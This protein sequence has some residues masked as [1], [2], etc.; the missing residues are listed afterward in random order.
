MKFLRT[1]AIHLFIFAL[2]GLPML[3]VAAQ[4][5]M[6]N[7]AN[8][9]GYLNPATY[10]SCGGKLCNPITLNTIEDFIVTV[11]E[12]ILTFAVPVAAFFIIYAGFTMVIDS[13]QGKNIAE[14]KKQF[15][16]AVIGTA[17]II[18]ALMLAKALKAT[19][20]ELTN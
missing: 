7:T 15:Y 1:I 16:G 12:V 19:V 9:N 2:I 20:L 4:G 11:L 6:I 8:Q 5:T 18:G 13:A 14:A 17:L 3:R 10:S